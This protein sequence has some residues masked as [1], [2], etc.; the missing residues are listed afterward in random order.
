MWI[1]V[2]KS[3]LHTARVVD[4][5]PGYEGSCAIDA[6]LLQAAGI[7]PHEQLH[8]YNLDN[9]HRFVTYAIAATAGSGMVSA[10]GAAAHLARPGQRLIICTYRQIAEQA[11][12]GYEPQL[13]Y[14]DDRNRVR[15]VRQSTPVQAA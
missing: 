15:R 13:V 9:A 12:A 2:L 11:A 1:T 10:N 7:F 5:N 14:L 4:A 8:V 6:M 3:K